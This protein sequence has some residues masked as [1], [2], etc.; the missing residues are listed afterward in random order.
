RS[1]L[2]PQHPAYIIYT[3]GSTGTPKGVVVSHR[4]LVNHMSWMMADHRVDERDVVLCRTAISFDAA[5]WEV[6]LPLLSGATLCVTP[7]Q[8]A[9]DP[10]Q[11]TT[12][13]N[14]HGLTHLHC[15]P[16]WLAALPAVATPDAGVNLRS[17]FLG[18]E[19]LASGLARDVIAAWKVPLVNLYGPTEAT[20]QV[21]SWLLH[22]ADLKSAA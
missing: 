5:G 6:W 16:S 7:S 20:I 21:P 19:S 4:G 22:D 17:L 11:F 9:H 15:V 13:L 10:T 2:A 18:G 3:S 1:G 8:L 14:H 12:Y